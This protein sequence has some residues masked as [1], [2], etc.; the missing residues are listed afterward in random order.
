MGY[1]IKTEGLEQ[2]NC[3]KRRHK[4]GDTLVET[5]Y[6]NEKTFGDDAMSISRIKEWYNPFKDVRTSVDSK[7]HIGMPSTS[8]NDNVFDQEANWSDRIFVSQSAILGT[9]WGHSFG[10]PIQC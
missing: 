3:I 1:C 10:R 4:S 8:R 2:R 7:L 6:K 9:G 5:V